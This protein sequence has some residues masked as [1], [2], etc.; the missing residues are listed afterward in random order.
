MVYFYALFGAK[1]STLKFPEFSLTLP[2]SPTFPDF[3][4]FPDFI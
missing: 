4:K 2:F 3:L 1:F